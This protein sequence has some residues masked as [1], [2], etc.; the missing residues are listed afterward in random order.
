MDRSV[1]CQREISKVMYFYRGLGRCKGHR[2]QV[3]PT[4]SAM[5][6]KGMVHS[7]ER[8]M[9]RGQCGGKQ[10]KSR[11]TT[12][13]E[14]FSRVTSLLIMQLTPRRSPKDIRDQESI[15]QMRPLRGIRSKLEETSTSIEADYQ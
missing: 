14:G 13:L 12:R 1:W 5:A 15:K 6:N 7:M 11:S 2:L 3:T 10:D 4:T 8:A 9:E